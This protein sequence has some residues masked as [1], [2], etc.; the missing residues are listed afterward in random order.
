[1]PIAIGKKRTFRMKFE[2]YSHRLT[3]KQ[4]LPG[5]RTQSA[6]QPINN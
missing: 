5:A 2:N 1:M 6:Q 3:V 4:T